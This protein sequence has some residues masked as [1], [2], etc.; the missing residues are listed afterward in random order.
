MRKLIVL[1]LAML[2]VPSSAVPSTAAATAF[3]FNAESAPA[4]LTGKQHAGNDTFS[5]D[6]GLVSC[7]EATYEEKELAFTPSGSITLIPKYE[8]CTAFGFPNVPVDVNGCSYRFEPQ[9]KEGGHFEGRLGIGCPVEAITVTAPG[10]TVTIPTQALLKAVTYTNV[11]TG[12]TRELTIDVVIT[13]MSYEEHNKGIF[14]TCAANT[15]AKTNGVYS[16]AW[17]LTAEKPTT[18]A[19]IGIFVG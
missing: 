13:G 18:K 16:S 8:G 9:T 4:T 10:C 12:A 17:L 19:H 1:V 14:P 11:G 3:N 5:F 7:N 6:A 15:K 2:V